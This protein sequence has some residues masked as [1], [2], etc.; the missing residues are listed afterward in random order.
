MTFDEILL[1]TAKPMLEKMLNAEMDEHLGYKKYDKNDNENSRNG[2]SSKN[3]NGLFGSTNIKTP[4]DR[5]ASFEPIVIKKNKHNISSVE[6]A[7]ILMYAKGSSTRDIT[8]YI[9]EIY[10]FD[11]DP[12]AISRITDKI[13]PDIEAFQNKPLKKLML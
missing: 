5:N 3:V 6:E 1:E 9:K 4:R 11:L 12:S 2:F 8:D 7:I 13:L 10:K